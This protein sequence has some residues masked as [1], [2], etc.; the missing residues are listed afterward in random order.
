MAPLLLAVEW[1]W[2]AVRVAMA[3]VVVAAVVVALA[4][5]V[6]AAG[7]VVMAL[8][9]LAVL[10]V[11][12]ILVIEHAAKVPLDVAVMVLVRALAAAAAVVPAKFYAKNVSCIEWS[13]LYYCYGKWTLVITAVHSGRGI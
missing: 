4:L 11:L 7:V 5:V 2:M 3:L 13:G 10:V 1:V 9:V 12:L 8:V 6:L